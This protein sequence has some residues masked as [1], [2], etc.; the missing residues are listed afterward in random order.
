MAFNVMFFALIDF[1]REASCTI[2]FLD[3]IVT[4][5]PFIR[6]EILIFS[7]SVVKLIIPFAV[8]LS[9]FIPAIFRLLSLLP[10]NVL[11]AF[12]SIVPSAF[13]KSESVE[14]PMLEEVFRITFPV[15][16]RAVKLEFV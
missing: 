1:S 11:F 15:V 16:F 2:F 6:P 14:L 12:A 4:L 10:R 8:A 7:F 13:T 5:P 9:L 3:E